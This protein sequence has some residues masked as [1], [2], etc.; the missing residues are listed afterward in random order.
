[1]G[2]SYKSLYPSI[3]LE[4]NI[5]PNTLIGKI[6]IP[7]KVYDHENKYKLEKY[8]RAGEFV[9]N[10]VTDN[11]IEFCH[12]WFHLANFMELLDDANEFF[13]SKMISNKSYIESWN[14]YGDRIEV[15]LVP[16]NHYIRNPFK[17]YRGPIQALHFKMP[18]E[19][20]EYYKE[21]LNVQTR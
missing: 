1:M 18:E 16:T 9:E 20:K 7:N 15:P 2:V 13:A 11:E 17:E 6:E 3:D 4:F 19:T 12:R 21:K 5:A 8:S 14:S 10:M